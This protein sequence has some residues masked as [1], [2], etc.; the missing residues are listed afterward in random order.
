ML[1]NTLFGYVS[2]FSFMEFPKINSA[3][4]QKNN[5]HN[6]F[7]R[8]DVYNEI[9]LRIQSK[10]MQPF[11][12]NGQITPLKKDFVQ[13]IFESSFIPFTEYSFDKFIY[14]KPFLL[15]F[16]SVIYIPDY[17]TGHGRI[18]NEE[19]KEILSN[20]PRNS[21]YVILNA[22]NIETIPYQDSKINRKFE[23]L[24]F[25]FVSKKD[26][27][28]HIYYIITKNEYNDDMYCIDWNYFDIE[29]LNLE[30]IDNLLKDI[31]ILL[32]R[33]MEYNV[34]NFQKIK[35]RIQKFIKYYSIRQ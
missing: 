19:E 16:N 3:L 14:E 6:I 23:V 5:P 29:T 34:N 9:Q 7:R 27:V 18:L 12:F 24:N 22:D 17:M 4:H 11:I 1:W 8:M 33:E 13:N 20:I 26:I 28:N 32:K 30:S 15:N 35:F 2:T 31:E 10:D 21:N 25:P